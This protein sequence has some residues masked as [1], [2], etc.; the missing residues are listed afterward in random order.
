M[1]TF[2]TTNRKNLFD[3][4]NNGDVAVFFAGKAPQ[5]TADSH[6][7]FRADKNFYYLTGTTRE[8]FILV[9]TKY[10]GKEEAV[11]FIEKPDYDIEKWVGRKLKKEDAQEV[12]GIE[13]IQYLSGFEA[14]FNRLIYSTK[15][16]AIYFDLARMQF[17][18]ETTAAMAFAKKVQDNYPGLQI[19]NIHKQMCELRM[20]KSDFE[21]DEIKKAIELTKNGLEAIM[22]NLKP[23]DREYAAQAEFNYSIMKNGADGNAFDTI[24]ASGENAVILHYVENNNVMNDGDLILMDL[25]AQKNQ[26]ASDITRT[27]P[28]NG[29]FTDRQRTLYNIVLKAHDEVIKIMKPGIPFSDLNKKC[30]EVLAEELIKIGLIEDAAG[31]GKYYY[32]GVSHFMGLD[33]HDIGFRE[34]NL[35]PGMIFTVEPGLYIAEEKIGIRLENDVLITKEGSEVLSKEIIIKPEDIEA[36]MAK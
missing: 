25:G 29:K 24:A 28:I 35:E 32:H 27:Y 14:Y 7:V 23:G 31:L 18:G 8:A 36:F 20:I 1:K 16:D 4:M 26:Y 3:K 17:D 9:M 34:V 33:V 10:E 5:S 2:F 11:L 6:Y 19:K 22:K 13:N 21:I 15:F 30:S 12:S